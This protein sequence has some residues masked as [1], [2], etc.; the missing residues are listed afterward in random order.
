M[1]SLDTTKITGEGTGQKLNSER[2]DARMKNRKGR[3]S[4]PLVFALS[5]FF[6]GLF[7]I[8]EKISPFLLGVLPFLFV[9][10]FL[11]NAFFSSGAKEYHSNKKQERT[12][13]QSF[14]LGWI[15]G[16]VEALT[17]LWWV[18]PTIKHFGH[19]PF[20]LALLSLFILSS[21]LGLFTGLVQ[22]G[23]DIWKQKKSA[24]SSDPVTLSLLGAC[25]WTI[26]EVLRSELFTGFPLNPL[27]DLIWGQ[28]LL[29]PN[30]SIIGATGMSFAIVFISGLLSAV[31]VPI[32]EKISPKRFRAQAFPAASILL[33]TV[34]TC[35]IMGGTLAK[36]PDKPGTQSI[37]VGIIQGNIPQDLKWTSQY[38]KDTLHTYHQLSEQAL[39]QGAKILLWP[40]T[41]I[42]VVIDSPPRSLVPAL[43][44]ALNLPVPLVTGTI[45]LVREPN[46]FGFSFS[47]DAI[48]RSRNGETLGRYT[49]MHLVPFGEYI[50]FPSIFGWLREMT[51][52]TG[53]LVPGNQQELFTPFDQEASPTNS[54]AY[55]RIRIGPIICYEAMYP[56]LVH[57]LVL[58]G[59]NLLVVFTDDAW[60]GKTAA[61]HQLYQQTMMRAIEEGV[62]MIRAANSGYSGVISGRG[63]LIRTSGRF[64]KESI[65]STVPLDSHETFYRKHGEWVF[66]ISLLIFLFLLAIREMEF[67]NSGIKSGPVQTTNNKS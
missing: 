16:M 38:L 23:L 50:P 9:P 28:K 6:L 26:M 14:F 34:F 67:H 66:R 21:Y 32:L 47:N 4:A 10:L 63:E 61:S 64:T 2:Q 55:G 31:I 22:F 15:F 54:D 33:L 24:S 13:G 12:S 62:P 49:K 20:I 65:T 57:Q 35:F 30:A 53:D 3:V 59:A 56:S 44:K 60:Y 43:N 1:I 46:R 25:L 18:V 48:V 11:P 41:A 29:I 7:F 36:K 51:G 39:I 52:I 42:P 8:P 19:L 58:K 45:G 40:E 37:K 5:G 27:G 17:S